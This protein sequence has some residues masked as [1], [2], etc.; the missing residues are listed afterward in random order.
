MGRDAKHQGQG[1]TGPADAKSPGEG[2]E[3]SSGAG[4]QPL[5]PPE[6]GSVVRILTSDD[7]DDG[8]V[9][10]RVLESEGERLLLRLPRN[11]DSRGHAFR[12]GVQVQLLLGRRDAA[13]LFQASILSRPAD[14]LM[15]VMLGGHPLRLQRREYFRISVRLPIAV[16]LIPNTDT[17]E[18]GTD[19]AEDVPADGHPRSATMGHR[20]DGS[21]PG[22]EDDGGTNVAD[23]YSQVPEIRIFRLADLSGGG[24]LCLDPDNVLKRGRLYPASLD[25]HDGEPALQVRFEVVR[26]GVSFGY[27][28]AGLRFVALVEKHRERIMRTL[29]R[30]YRARSN[31]GNP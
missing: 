17:E 23:A 10:A 18:Y 31:P 24:C 16:K 2:P 19:G 1:A 13:H 29:F 15:A 12:S 26:R 4:T 30:E 22:I 3:R 6:V 28:S 11:H 14:G 8:G 20:V 21:T 5:S 25:L 27:P 9:P 7:E